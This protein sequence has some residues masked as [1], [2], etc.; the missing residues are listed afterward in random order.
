MRPRKLTRRQFARALRQGRGAAFLHVKEY[1]DKDKGIKEEILNACLNNLVYD[2]QCETERSAWLATIID[3]TGSPSEYVTALL[4]ALRQGEHTGKDLEQQINLSRQLF[5][6]G[7]FE[8]ADIIAQLTRQKPLPFAALEVRCSLVE[9]FG[10]PG[11][12]RAAELMLDEQDSEWGIHDLYEYTADALDSE[13]S[14]REYLEA[15]APNNSKLTAVIKIIDEEKARSTHAHSNVEEN[16]PDLAEVL[17]KI[18]KETTL[19]RYPGYCVRFGKSASPED[20][21]TILNRIET[22]SNEIKLNCYLAVFWCRAIPR[23]PEN[24]RELLKTNNKTLHRALCRALGNTASLQVREL[25]LSILLAGGA[26]NFLTALRILENSCT[27]DIWLSLSAHL[28]SLKT[29]EQLHSA[30][31]AILNIYWDMDSHVDP[32][33]LLWIC[34]HTPCSF[35]RQSALTKLMTEGLAPESTVFEAQWDANYE[36]RL[37]ART[38]LANQTLNCSA[39]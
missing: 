34:E 21:E 15:N 18:D 37:A 17:E 19:F 32:G 12:A 14:V 3:R 22:T 8:F 2:R 26:E 1:G 33:P 20:L 9:M 27:T 4:A 7:Y 29:P 13:N 31:L 11:F 28:T 23:L 6:H 36:M 39:T 35:C 16:I 10:L 30:G 5:E 25:A 24:S 38:H